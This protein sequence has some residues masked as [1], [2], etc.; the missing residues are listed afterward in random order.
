MKRGE[1]LNE[2]EYIKILND[3]GKELQM[4]D[5]ET[6]KNLITRLE[7]KYINRIIELKDEINTLKECKIILLNNRR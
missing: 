5:F 1:W 2:L 4:V 6:T 3:D 7:D